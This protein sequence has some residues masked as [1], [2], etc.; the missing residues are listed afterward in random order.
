MKTKTLHRTIA[1]LAL[2]AALMMAAMLAVAFTHE[3][4]TAQDFEAFME[5][6]AYSSM[7][8]AFESSIRAILTFDSFFLLF[9]TA[10]FILLA[11]ALKDKDNLWLVA[12]GIGALLVTTYLD[13]HE[14]NELLVFLQMG[15]AGSAPTAEMLHARALWSA[16]KFQ[17][18]YLSFFLF[19]FVLPNKTT[20]EKFLRWSLW[21]GYV[22][23]GILTYTYPNAWFS[24]LRYVF[25]LSGLLILAWNFWL[26]S[27][28]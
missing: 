9:Y 16:V 23:I 14:N 15:H 2:A 12:T 17:S 1:W 25:M 26:R 8:L 21:L 24:L 6:Q 19:A 18:S 22:P 20:L 5:P 27:K 11:M 10:A 7:L 28:K 4:T 3:G 13:I